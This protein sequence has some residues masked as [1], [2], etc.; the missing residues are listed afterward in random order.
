MKTRTFFALVAAV[1]PAVTSAGCAR[2]SQ[3]GGAS[4]SVDATASIMTYEQYVAGNRD[5][6]IVRFF[7]TSEGQL[8]LVGIGHTFEAGNQTTGTIY[9]EW[10]GFNPSV[11][12]FEGV[13]WEKGKS[14][15]V[16]EKHGEPAFVRFMAFVSRVPVMSIEPDLVN[17]IRHLQSTWSDSQ[18]RSFYAL[19]MMAEHFA[20]NGELPTAQ[21]IHSFLNLWFPRLDDFSQEPSTY[22]ALER[23]LVKN[24]PPELD[25]RAPK[26]SWIEPTADLTLFNEIA[27]DSGRFRDERILRVLLSEVQQ[28]ERVY[29]A[30]GFTHA[31][32]LEPAISSVLGSPTVAPHG[33]QQCVAADPS[34]ATLQS[35]G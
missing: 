11:A 28:G 26:R 21:S 14:Q 9:S 10:S 24:L 30:V 20:A 15:E 7:D 33:A 22:E 4:S 1:V 2:H 3:G 6:P 29:F 25:V 35:G 8:C 31:H 32:M 16:I 13:G 5:G 23:V 12:F 19:R 18:I 34:S 27:R 17:E